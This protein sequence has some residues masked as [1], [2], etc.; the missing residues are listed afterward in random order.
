VSQSQLA[1]YKRG[2]KSYVVEIQGEDHTLGNLIVSKLL[3]LDEVSYAYYE[4]PH[5]LEDKLIIYVN[6]KS[7][8]VDVRKVLVK[9]AEAALRDKDEFERLYR[10]ALRK[11]GVE[12]ED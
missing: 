8:D 6:L 5:P 12:L 4:V 1:I 7:D 11:R 3:E 2:P 9:A 10:E